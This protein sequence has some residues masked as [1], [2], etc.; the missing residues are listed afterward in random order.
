MNSG[1]F[2]SESLSTEAETVIEA[3]RFVTH[4]PRHYLNAVLG[5]VFIYQSI[6][7]E[8]SINLIKY[9]VNLIILSISLVAFL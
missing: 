4:K 3:L 7:A 2:R 6:F 5:V 8:S 9:S 1:E